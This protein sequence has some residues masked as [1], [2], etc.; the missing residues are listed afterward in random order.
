L[1]SNHFMGAT[2]TR[3]LAQLSQGKRDAGAGL[4]MGVA[5]CVALSLAIAVLAAAR[6]GEQGITTAL[7]LTGRLS[8]LFFWPAYAGSAIAVLFGRRFGLFARY[9]REFGL[10]YASAQLVHVALVTWLIWGSHR[11]LTEGIMPFFAVGVVWTYVLAFSSVERLQQLFNPNFWRILRNLGL[12]YIALVFFADF[13]FGPIEGGVKHPIAY[14]PFALLLIVG[15]LLRVA[16]IARR[17]GS[18]A[19]ARIFRTPLN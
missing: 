17:A 5:F 2:S 8:F 3:W 1:T 13:V 16:A 10:A 18:G 6:A 12:E 9:G 19:R 11:P 7:R 4:W 14:V 15:S